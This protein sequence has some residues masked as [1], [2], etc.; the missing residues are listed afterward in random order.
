MSNLG[1]WTARHL[2]RFA[3][4]AV[5]L[6]LSLC[7]TVWGWRAALERELEARA[8]RFREQAAIARM[9]L[10]DRLE[11]LVLTTNA[12]TGL[13]AASREI[14]EH[15]WVRFVE[16]LDIPRRLPGVSCMGLLRITDHADCAVPHPADGLPDNPVTAAS[17]HG[18]TVSDDLFSWPDDAVCAVTPESLWS[19][20]AVRLALATSRDRGRAVAVAPPA[21]PD[22]TSNI[23][24]VAAVFAGDALTTTIAQRRAGLIGWVVIPVSLEALVDDAIR[25][26]S[27]QM[28]CNVYPGHSS[29]SV[30]PD[31]RSAPLTGRYEALLSAEMFEW[32]G[33]V[34]TLRMRPRDSFFSGEPMP[35]QSTL[36]LA[37]M[38]LVSWLLTGMTWALNSG[39]E[40]ARQL[41]QRMTASL[42]RSELEARK[43]A[44][45]AS[46]TS[47][48]VAI[49]GPDGRIEWINRGFARMT[50]YS[51][52][53]V[54]GQPLTDLLRPPQGDYEG[55]ITNDERPTAKSAA[56]ATHSSF[57]QPPEMQDSPLPAGLSEALLLRR[58][59]PASWVSVEIQPVVNDAGHVINHVAIAGDITERKLAERE[60]DR[61]RA[62]LRTFVELTPT[63]IAMLDRDL[64][65]IAVS[66]RWR[67]E[68]AL[69][70]LNPEGMRHGELF[71]R[72]A[73]APNWLEAIHA[74]LQ[75]RP[76]SCA[77]DH[78]VRRDGVEAWLW[79]EIVPWRD[80]DGTIGGV[81]IAA[82]IITDHIR[83]RRAL[84]ESERFARSTV[85]ALSAHI[86][87]LDETGVILA[88]NRAWREFAAANSG[89]PGRCCE[90]VSYLD[91]CDNAA[92][93][94][95]A[96]AVRMAEAIRGTI[97]GE[98]ESTH[99]EYPCHGR[100]EQRWFSAR[101]T[102][103]H[104]DGP[105][106]VVVAHEN[107]T[108]RK[109]NELRASRH[110]AELANAMA[111]A[112]ERA[113]ALECQTA[114]LERL[115]AQA[116]LANR[117]KSEFLANMSHEIRTPMT[118][119]L[120]YAE[121][122]MDPRT[123][124]AEQAS[125][126]GTIRRNG[127]HLLTIIND[128]LD[129]SKIEAGRL[130]VERVETPL[131]E[132][133]EEVHSLMNVRAV[134]R[135]IELFCE[136]ESRIPTT[137]RTDP[138]R[139]RQVLTNLVGNAIKFTEK[140]EVRV[141]VGLDSVDVPRPRIR[142]EVADTGIGMTPEQVGRLFE[143]FA[144]ADTS[145]TRR[146]GGTGLG[147]VISQRLAKA[148]GGD[149]QVHSEP[150]KGSRFVV[151]ID[152]GPIDRA[153]MIA[154]K[155]QAG[156]MRQ[157]ARPAETDATLRGRVLL[158]EDGPDNQRLIALVLRKA[159]LA[160]EIAGNGR[161]AFE[162]A[163]K[164]ASERLPFDLILMDMQM[165]EM[166]GYS[167][168][169]LLRG[170]GYSGPIIALTANAM[171]SDRERCLAAGCDDYATKPI[172][173]RIL[174]ALIAEHLRKRERASQSSTDGGTGSSDR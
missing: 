133:V 173:R 78:F 48:A 156:V 73:D 82:E 142:I 110:A 112:E 99:I 107:I 90:N 167:A 119:I 154:E 137:I 96:E 174:I 53:E 12:A 130:T 11:R 169:S 88:V 102:R 124:P 67:R 104:G 100:G 68:F 126:I 77:E 84:A 18:L 70:D 166:D 74:A 132:L 35:A 56:P 79:W 45:V 64:R 143:P 85:D 62:L 80:E 134:E 59:G 91:V 150:G 61:S 157:E 95:C 89:D 30:S 33:Q 51:A 46:R 16:W 105:V 151:L 87:I 81:V 3:P 57:P 171:A 92:G 118:A 109:L 13:F 163:M 9:A 141:K 43:L 165:P 31:R 129:L 29:A 32:G 71:A 139:L 26:H 148:L 146:F 27:P 116:D 149:I 39:G 41:A 24:L 144:Q 136:V 138:V 86:A 36:V 94:S 19:D 147:L 2:H 98:R 20:P 69:S 44:M 122:L 63:A 140:G 131:W 170:S 153:R 161:I 97:R 22:A 93:D 8:A 111:E 49:T 152:P 113:L 28:T 159:G 160:V 115:R 125:H 40:R 158:A 117:S 172:D 83:T 155:P 114:E 101:V 23:M 168:T 66:D 14:E 47:N 52:P 25:Q 6:G 76:Q 72:E 127:E 120:G 34:W 21:A 108:A 128:I 4:V 17:L 162:K 164:A 55:R 58:K 135:K 38:L 106:R 10:I 7:L 50:G 65:Y 60:A 75:G 42:A 54:A 1:P 121:L 5:V 15:E 103:F 37:L 123:G 145:T